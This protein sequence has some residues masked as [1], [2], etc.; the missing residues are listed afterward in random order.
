MGLLQS[1][2]SLVAGHI[3]GFLGWI[4]A[5]HNFL[6]DIWLPERFDPSQGPVWSKD[7]K[8]YPPS[9]IQDIAK[10][11]VCSECRNSHRVATKVRK[12][13]KNPS[14]PSFL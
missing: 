6:Y 4:K 1:I 14:F 9:Q 8:L 2:L 10:K 3:Q 11:T 5:Y 13:M 7:L 12:S